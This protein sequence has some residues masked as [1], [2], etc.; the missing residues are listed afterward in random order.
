MLTVTNMATVWIVVI[1]WR[2]ITHW[3]S[4]FQIIHRNELL[5]CSMTITVFGSPIWQMETF[6]KRRSYQFFADVSYIWG[7]VFCAVSKFLILKAVAAKGVGKVDKAGKVGDCPE[8][9]VPR[10]CSS[11]YRDCLS[12][13]YC[14]CSLPYT[15]VLLSDTNSS[16]EDTQEV[17]NKSLWRVNDKF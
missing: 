4:I 1:I 7:S 12:S 11:I 5:N 6:E 14:R 10:S 17:F 16:A 2:N 8:P 15:C 13:S 9:L 3:K